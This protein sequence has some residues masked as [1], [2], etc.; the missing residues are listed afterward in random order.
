MAPM[1][2][3]IGDISII[4]PWMIDGSITSSGPNAAAIPEPITMNRLACGLRF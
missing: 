2:K 3:L 1:T 4:K